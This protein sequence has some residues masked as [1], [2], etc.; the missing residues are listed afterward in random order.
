MISFGNSFFATMAY[1]RVWKSISCFYFEDDAM[2]AFV[3]EILA[4]IISL[5]CPLYVCNCFPF[6]FHSLTVVSFE[7]VKIYSPLR[8]KF[9][10]V[11]WS[12]WPSNRPSLAMDLMF[13]TFRSFLLTTVAIV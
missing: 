4:Q 2:I 9:T 3:G 10:D 12:V 11:I 1:V 8:L 6:K 13:H 7:P 5:S